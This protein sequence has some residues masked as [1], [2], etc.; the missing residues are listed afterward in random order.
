VYYVQICFFFFFER[1]ITIKKKSAGFF[2][3]CFVF[4]M[5][6]IVY[7]KIFWVTRENLN[8]V[9]K[10]VINENLEYKKNFIYCSSIEWFDTYKNICLLIVKGVKKLVA[11]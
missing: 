10:P 2:P 4:K 3:H 7:Y 11:V 6:Y 8:Y 9:C 5:I 1:I